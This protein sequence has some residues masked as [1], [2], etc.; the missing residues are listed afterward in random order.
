ML[1][2]K[3]VV[4]AIATALASSCAHSNTLPPVSA[5]GT[6]SASTESSDALSKN[7]RWGFSQTKTTGTGLAQD[8]SHGTWFISSPTSI[9]EIDLSKKVTTITVPAASSDPV[10]GNDGSI[11][12][13]AGS[14][15][16]RLTPTGAVSYHS[17]PGLQGQLRLMTPGF[18]NDV[19]FTA[20]DG[21]VGHMTS[22]GA[23]TEYQLQPGA[24]PDCPGV[25][26]CRPTGITRGPDGNIWFTGHIDFVEFSGL[27]GKINPTT[28]VL[29]FGTGVAAGTFASLVVGP[30]ARIWGLCSVPGPQ[31]NV[32]ALCATSTS[33]VSTIYSLPDQY[34]YQFDWGIAAGRDAIYIMATNAILRF[35]TNGQI[36]ATYTL[37]S[38]IACCMNSI[39]ASGPDGDVWF[40][41]ENGLGVLKP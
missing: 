9:S 1:T 26:L 6:T 4:V 17:V 8:K 27:I 14:K 2:R 28:G 24:T 19:W 40:S 36:A 7:L 34:Q 35:S 22:N 13:F 12:F 30:D 16:G 41:T 23:V 33:F 20:E 15:I 25:I 29:T 39:S 11:W 21:F 3:I 18:A 5:P 31:E 37:P 38:S 10:V 32:A